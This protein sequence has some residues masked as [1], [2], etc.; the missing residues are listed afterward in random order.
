MQVFSTEICEIFKN[1]FFE[2][3]LRKTASFLFSEKMHWKH[4]WEWEYVLN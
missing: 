4:V 1:P 3:Y 2:V